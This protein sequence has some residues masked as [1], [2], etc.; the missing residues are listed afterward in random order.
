MGRDH[1]HG[2]VAQ[3][4]AAS[5]T[6]SIPIEQGS[7]VACRRFM[8]IHWLAESGCANLRNLGRTK[9]DY[10]EVIELL[11]MIR[12]QA[13]QGLYLPVTAGGPQ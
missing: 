4:G 11:G 3:A 8:R 6:T 7:E 1:Q 12:E 2:G 10:E 13:E 5:T 9:I